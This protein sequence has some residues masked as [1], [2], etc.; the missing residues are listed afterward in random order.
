MREAIEACLNTHYQETN[1]RFRLFKTSNF[2]IQ[3]NTDGPNKNFK[4]AFNSP[5]VEMRLDGYIFF[6]VDKKET[7]K[8]VLTG[9]KLN[10]YKRSVFIWN[11]IVIMNILIQITRCHRVI[12]DWRV[13]LSATLNYV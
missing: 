7:A 9:D 13:K 8:I 6:T 12:I 11:L 4:Y 10:K 3:N 5:E 2:F 1:K